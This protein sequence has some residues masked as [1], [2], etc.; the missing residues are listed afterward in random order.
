MLNYLI[1]ALV[2]GNN[3]N[4]GTLLNPSDMPAFNNDLFDDA[5]T[6][7]SNTQI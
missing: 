4:F 5:T 7:L 2:L 1:Q 6:I 3:F